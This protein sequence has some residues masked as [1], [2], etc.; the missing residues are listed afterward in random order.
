MCELLS[1]VA[2][3]SWAWPGG[4]SC[5]SLLN[6]LKTPSINWEVFIPNAPSNFYNLSPIYL[7]HFTP[8]IKF[9]TR[10]CAGALGSALV[11]CLINPFQKFSRFFTS[12]AFFFFFFF[13]WPPGIM[14]KPVFFGFL[15]KIM[16]R[17][18]DV[19]VLSRCS[20]M[21]NSATSWRLSGSSVH[22][23]LPRNTGVGCHFLFHGIFLTQGSN[24]GLL[25]FLQWQAGILPLVPSGKYDSGNSNRCS[26]TI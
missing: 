9:T 7:R 3:Q 17:Y 10:I 23:I 11:Q 8:K 20:V 21:T 25:C 6:T 12:G 5:C 16:L 22:G 24:L 1:P 18:T 2:T 4:F 14:L 19:C 15:S 13:C 26:V